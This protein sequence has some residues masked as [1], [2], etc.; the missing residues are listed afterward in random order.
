MDPFTLIIIIIFTSSFPL[1]VL[2][3][4]IKYNKN[5]KFEKLMFFYLI[6]SSYI[7]LGMANF[8]YGLIKFSAFYGTLELSFLFVR[9]HHSLY[10]LG[11]SFFGHF[12]VRLLY[13]NQPKFYRYSALVLIILYVLIVISFS[14]L[15]INPINLRYDYTDF[16]TSITGIGALGTLMVGGLMFTYAL[17]FKLKSSKPVSKNLII[18]KIMMVI[19]AWLIGIF[20]S[21]FYIISFDIPMFILMVGEIIFLIGYVL[22]EPFKFLVE[23]II[24]KS[25]Q[26][27]ISNQIN[28]FKHNFG[29]ELPE[30]S[31]II[32]LFDDINLNNNLLSRLLSYFKISNV[33]CVLI[34][35][36]GKFLKLNGSDSKNFNITVFEYCVDKN[37][38]GEI[39]NSLIRVPIDLSILYETLKTAH[40]SLQDKKYFLLFDSITDLIN[41][42]GFKPVYL[43]LR[44]INDLLRNSKISALFSIHSNAHERTELNKILNSF[45]GILQQKE[46]TFELK[47]FE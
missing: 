22:H 7:S 9:I 17:I 16:L 28:D 10:Y 45:D 5:K 35:Q 18:S 38:V 26:D 44:K 6:L 15:P 39:E 20:T 40:L 25:K 27:E 32:L 43:F 31:Q 24:Q 47:I 2:V 33:Q 23:N 14:V 3:I 37:S 1:F 34:T 13:E 29:F 36:K 12:L 41:W 42:H 4:L 30:N 8:L 46:N 19:G 11:M 21:V